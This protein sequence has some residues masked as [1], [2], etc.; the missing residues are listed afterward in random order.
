M[1]EA[2]PAAGPSRAAPW[3][4]GLKVAVVH[5]WL[6]GMRGGEKV[7]ESICE[8]FPQ[9]DLFT[10]VYDPEAVSPT[11]RRHKV[12]T[13]FI[14]GLPFAKTRYPYYLPLMPLALE[15]LD[16]RGYDLIISTESGPA[17]GVIAP[18]SAVHVCY[19]HSPMRYL[20]NMYPDY[21]AEAGT[22]TRALMPPLMHYL[23]L[24]DYA[25]AARV[26]HFIANSENVARRIRRYWKRDAEVICPP[27]DMAAFTPGEAPG[28]HYLFVGQLTAYKRADLAIEA[29]NRSGRRLVVVGHGEEEARMRKRAGPTVDVRGQVPR[30]ELQALMSG[31]RG[32]IFPNEEDFGIVALEAM[33]AGRPVVAFARGGALETVVEGKTGVFFDAPTVDAL[34]AAV[35]RLEAAEASFDPAALR[36]HAGDFS[37]EAFEARLGEAVRRAWERE[38]A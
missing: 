38:R 2:E 25:A 29:F 6:V 4:R 26:D 35:D 12:T 31:C 14:Q 37:L 33:A 11:I 10:H 5:Y 34:N 28:D 32:L 21:R 8:L 23:R 3:A 24:W 36:A 22:L 20:W 19:C 13:T 30:A 9:A 16:L 17:K 27:V 1:A 7:L 15:Q 18:P